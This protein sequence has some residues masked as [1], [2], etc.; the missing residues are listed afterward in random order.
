MARTV[1][2][3][4]PSRTNRRFLI[5]AVLLAAVSA[6]LVYAKIAADEDTGGGS[7][8]GD[9]QQVVV[10]KAEIPANSII[11]SDMLTIENVDANGIATGALSDPASAIGRVTKYE[12]PK[13]GQIVT[14]AIVDTNR[15][16]DVLSQVVPLGKRAVSINASQVG[17]AGGLV[18]PG[19]YVDVV[20]ACCQGGK[21]ITK[22]LLKNVQVLTVAQTILPSAPVAGTQDAPVPGPDGPPLPDAS[23]VNLLLTPQ[24]AQIVFLAEGQGEFRLALRGDGDD[25]PVETGSSILT[26]ILTPEEL[27]RLPEGLKPEGYRQQP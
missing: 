4:A 21:V 24:E 6:V 26:D 17:N 18:L 2:G 14:S 9:A 5:I 12:V 15:P 10:A 1:A 11:T 25:A 8:S 20:W 7:A 13:N 19:D 22:T 3:A 23:T 16:A 27:A